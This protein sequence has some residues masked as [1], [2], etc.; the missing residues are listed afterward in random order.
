MSIGT[1]I[2]PRRLGWRSHGHG[3]F[4]ASGAAMAASDAEG[5]AETWTEEEASE[6]VGDLARPAPAQRFG[7]WD[8]RI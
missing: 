7:Q 2:S 5:S 3:V 4:Q 6:A 8:S 1:G